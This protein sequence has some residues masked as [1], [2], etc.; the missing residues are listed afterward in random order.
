M[1]TLTKKKP[2]TSGNVKNLGMVSKKT[3]S[4]G[5]VLQAYCNSVLQQAQVDF[6]ADPKLKAIS[7]E[8]NTSLAQAK[9]HG[10]TFLNVISPALLSSLSGLDNYC[11]LYSSVPTTLPPGSTI[12]Q[13]LK[14]L[15]ALKQFSEKSQRES[16]KIV[17]QLQSLDTNLR[18]DSQAFS[19][20]VSRLNQL[21]NGDQ[22]ELD[23]IKSEL[24]H[25]DTTIAGAITASV[26]EG[27]D[28][29]GGVVTI[30]VGA[31]ADFVTAGTNPELVVGG[32]VMVVAGVGAET[33]TIVTLASSYNQKAELLEEKS[34]LTS[35]V[36]LVTGI[37]SAYNLLSNQL[38]KA[39]AAADLM[40][41][42]WQTIADDLENLIDDLHSGIITEGQVRTLF[43]KEANTDIKTLLSEIKIIKDQMAG[44]S[45]KVLPKGETVN[46]YLKQLEKGHTVAPIHPM[47]TMAIHV[48]D[49]PAHE[50]PDKVKSVP[51]KIFSL[52]MSNLDTLVKQLGNLVNLPA[53]AKG[54]RQLSKK[55]IGADISHLKMIQKQVLPYATSAIPNLEKALEDLKKNPHHT[56]QVVS[57]IDEVHKGALQ[58]ESSIKRPAASIQDTKVQMLHLSKQLDAMEQGFKNKIID[59]K[60]KAAIASK[61]IDFY[62]KR[63]LYFLALGPLGLVGL[64]IALGFIISWTEKANNLE[65]QENSLHAQIASIKLLLISINAMNDYFT[66]IIQQLSGIKNAI[67]FL[68][69]DITNIM[70]DLKNSNTTQAQLYLT[71][72]IHELK[73]LK[74]DVS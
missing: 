62:T 12:S 61:K 44:V 52:L 25:I 29:L 14:E 45:S 7:T 53:S 31:I 60:T 56:S 23:K 10:T 69:G 22:G 65:A 39:V 37:D 21:V 19:K 13:W 41:N 74:M 67:G 47:R 54:I 17:S 24:S 73:T 16:R 5:L 66:K 43:L 15:Q 33:G 26:F 58:L 59:L 71:T 40:E 70:N 20:I 6:S 34:S 50:L 48:E 57:L 38:K 35:E 68:S 63:K 3:L 30:A 72:A 11:T 36:N 4:Q 18:D 46:T 55:I 2:V 64:G 1:N 28:I 51:K 9:S 32:V 27:L 42:T 49:H 8:I